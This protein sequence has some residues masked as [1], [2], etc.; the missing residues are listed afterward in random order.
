MNNHDYVKRALSS[1]DLITIDTSTLMNDEY[2][3][4]FVD[5]YESL[6][7][8]LGK[9]IYVSRSVW[10]EL[11]RKY[12]CRDEEKR[13]K[14]ANAICTLNMHRNI[15]RIDDTSVD[16]D[17][18]LNAFADKDLLS[19]LT[20]NITYQSQLL[21]TNDG[22]LANDAWGL[23]KLESCQ[24]RQVEVCHILYTGDLC[25]TC[26]TKN[27]TPVSE[28]TAKI[29]IVYRDRIK[30]K[31]VNNQEP[32]CS[33]GNLLQMAGYILAFGSGIVIGKYGKR[34]IRPISNYIGKALIG[35]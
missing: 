18:I 17:E 27:G 20:R 21:I 3:Q 5:N 34:I 22:K 10:A 9:M 26:L 30:E 35:R 31:E 19:D 16:S 24:G 33:R 11:L 4:R 1:F 14:A 15:F 25:L 23:N 32:A 8:E 12:N 2:L 13:N 28:R 6:I 29:Q 7:L